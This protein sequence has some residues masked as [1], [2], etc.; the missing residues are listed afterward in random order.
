[1][2]KKYPHTHLYHMRPIWVLFII[3]M[4]LL[5][6]ACQQK[7]A[8]DVTSF[9]TEILTPTPP[10]DLVTV[11][12]VL[13]PRQNPVIGEREVMEA[14]LTGE[15]IL[16]EGCLRVKATNS[17]SN[18]M[19]IWPPGFNLNLQNDEFEILD[20][21]SQITARVG[22]RVQTGGG[23]VPADF[24]PQEI[25]NTCPGPYFVVGDWHVVIE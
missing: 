6:T 17:E 19:L 21:N 2:L 1:M 22:D 14:D 11:S 8:I 15:L 20:G 7:S 4:L 25:R 12:G 10:I 9:P 5:A 23:E 3:I 13:F 18:Y 24:L 16:S